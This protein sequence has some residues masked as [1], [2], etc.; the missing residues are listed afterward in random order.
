MAIPD[1]HDGEATVEVP[2][3]LWT[4]YLQAK[5]EIAEWTKRA[6][7]A[8]RRLEEIIGDRHAG[9]VNGAKVVTYRPMDRYAVQ[10][11]RAAYPDLTASYVVPRLIDEFDTAAFAVHHP[12]IAEQYR[13][14]QLR[15]V[16]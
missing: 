14:R 10:K 9:T 15:I 16:E 7:D 11:L 13:S 4:Q 8:R 1:P 2:A 12:D 3:A 5:A 6:E